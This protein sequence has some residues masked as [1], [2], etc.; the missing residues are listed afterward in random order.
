MKRIGSL[1]DGSIC[2]RRI[3]GWFS[4]LKKESVGNKELKIIAV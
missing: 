1:L 2:L 4:A 3:S